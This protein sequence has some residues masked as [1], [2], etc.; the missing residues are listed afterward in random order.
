[1]IELFESCA[2]IFD[3]VTLR[4]YGKDSEIEYLCLDLLQRPTGQLLRYV[5]TRMNGKMLILVCTN[6]S[7]K[8]EQIIQLY[9]KRFGIE[10]MFKELKHRL[11][12][13]AYHFWT[14]ALPKRKRGEAAEVAKNIEQAKEEAAK[15]SG[16]TERAKGDAA[17]V[18]EDTEQAKGDAAKVSKDT[19]QVKED[20]A[21]VSGDAEQVKGEAV[22]VS[23]DTEQAKEDAVKVSEDT[24]QAQGEA[25]KVSGDTERAEKVAQSKTAIEVFV[26]LQC[27]A[28]IILTGL[29][30]NQPTQIMGRFTGWLRTVRTQ[31]PTVMV[32][33]QVLSHDFLAFV[34]TLGHL[35]TFK[36][37]IDDMRDED[38]LYKTS[39]AA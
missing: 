30:V 35:P 25:A 3:K 26:C 8:P 23:E 33:K 7:L 20:A 32:A 19:E 21:K 38:S 24:G 9:A 17:K 5:L 6:L 13:F 1:M 18:S 15:V 12:A 36:E 10:H 39:D 37:V 11:G 28:Y 2:D 22:K 27:I 4:L 16:D 29:A 14:R 31:I 34:R